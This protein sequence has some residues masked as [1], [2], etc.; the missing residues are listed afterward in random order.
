MAWA[1]GGLILESDESTIIPS[2]LSR[3]EAQKHE[4]GHRWCP[5]HAR[6]V[7]DTRG[8]CRQIAQIYLAWVLS[9]AVLR[10]VRSCL[11][12]DDERDCWCWVV[13]VLLYGSV[14]KNQGKR[15]TT[16]NSALDN[17]ADVFSWKFWIKKRKFSKLTSPIRTTLKSGKE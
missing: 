16:N 1:S 13:A 8:C 2:Q 6:H 4:E 11:L 14:F 12:C 15:L 17:N 9:S 5:R 3:H 10:D 7:P